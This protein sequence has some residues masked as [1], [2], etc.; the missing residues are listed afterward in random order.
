MNTAIAIIPAR[1]GSK[2]I[3]KKNI[4][5]LNGKPLLAYTLEAAHNAQCFARILVSTDSEEIAQVA[6]QYQAEVIW[7]PADLAS[8]QA[9][10][11]AA[12]LHGL[13]NLGT[14]DPPLTVTLPPTSPLRSAQSIQQVMQIFEQNGAE[15]D[16]AFS[17]TENRGDFWQHN[18]QGW[19]RLFPDAPRRRQD[20]APLYEENSAIYLTRTAALRATR[21]ILGRRALGVPIPPLEALDINDPLDVLW[22]E[23]VIS[24]R[25][26]GLSLEG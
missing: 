25:Q 16:A 12:L 4:Y 11:E 18:A 23:F 9:S 17:V 10:T 8:D 21:F 7:R 15:Y 22:A 6:V 13:D 24:R 14:E 5:P 20:R 1:G 3:P 2:R 19:Q 26:A